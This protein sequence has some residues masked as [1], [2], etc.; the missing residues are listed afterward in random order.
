MRSVELDSDAIDDLSWWIENDR[1]EAARI[2][3]LLREIQ[4]EPFLGTGKPEPL[5]HELAG[6]WSRRIN[7]SDR[8]VYQVLTDRIRVLSCRHHYRRNR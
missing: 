4:R 3:R 6:C 5:K 8:I 2:M 7:S 1:K